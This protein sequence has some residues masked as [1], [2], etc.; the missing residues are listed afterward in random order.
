MHGKPRN[1][2][3]EEDP[4]ASQILGEQ[5]LQ[6]LDQYLKSPTKSLAAFLFRGRRGVDRNMTRTLWG[7][8]SFC[9]ATSTSKA[10]PRYLGIDVGV[11]LTI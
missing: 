11:A 6:A 9:L 2:A 10:R 7:L 1:G 3:I 5:T 8:S 4:A